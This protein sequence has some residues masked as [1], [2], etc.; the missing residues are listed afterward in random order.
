MH[1]EIDSYGEVGI[2]VVT[3]WC[4]YE[5]AIELRVTVESLD[6]L[7]DIPIEDLE[8]LTR[9]QDLSAGEARATRCEASVNDVIELVGVFE[10][11]AEKLY[12]LKVRHIKDSSSDK[13]NIGVDSPQ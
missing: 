5:D 13:E 6:A 9:D 12:K 1:V 10:G 4:E 11:E 2:G 7:D 8:E 3:L